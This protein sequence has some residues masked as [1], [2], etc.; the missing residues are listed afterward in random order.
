LVQLLNIEVPFA[1]RNL[2][3]REGRLAPAA[4][5]EMACLLSEAE[6]IGL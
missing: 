2:S 4:F 5:F 1:Q 6:V 3:G